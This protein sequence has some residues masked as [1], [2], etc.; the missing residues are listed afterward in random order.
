MTIIGC[1]TIIAIDLV[2]K[3]GIHSTIPFRVVCAPNLH[4][5]WIRSVS[6][7]EKRPSFNRTDD[8]LFWLLKVQ[9]PSGS[10]WSGIL[11]GANLP[12]SW[13]KHLMRH[14][15]VFGKHKPPAACKSKNEMLSK[16]K[17]LQKP[18]RTVRLALTK[19]YRSEW[20]RQKTTFRNRSHSQLK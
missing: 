14:L 17:R 6:G 9:R 13:H 10:A 4:N 2:G 18:K 12:L 5:D 16:S 19:A 15:L 8:K 3:T 11:V 1:K 20:I 7:K